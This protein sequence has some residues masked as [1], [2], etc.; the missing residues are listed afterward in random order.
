MNKNT[1]TH[2]AILPPE[3]GLRSS[4]LLRRQQLA[5]YLQTIAHPAL[6]ERPLSEAL[7]Q[8]FTLQACPAD[9]RA[10]TEAFI[11]EC[12]RSAY[13]ADVKKFMPRLFELVTRRGELTAAFGVRSAAEA[14]LFLETYLDQPIELAMEARLGY[15]PAREKIVEVG[16][17]AAIYPGAVRWLIVALTVELYQQGYKWVVFTGTT[18][19]K[20]GFHRLGLRPVVLAAAD[21]A[22]LPEADRADWG[23]Y[24]ATRPAVMVGNI[25]YGFDEIGKNCQFPKAGEVA[26]LDGKSS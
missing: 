25:A 20:N 4:A 1:L 3:M 23:S 18:E 14:S 11:H 9:R 13:R 10:T 15:R 16:N 8:L 21:I 26:Y 5:S 12:F 6:N 22:R 17:L 7:E 19:L 2:K 24:Y